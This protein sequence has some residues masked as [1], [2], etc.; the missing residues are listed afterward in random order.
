M[1]QAAPAAGGADG[2]QGAVTR[3]GVGEEASVGRRV[4]GDGGGF[5]GEAVG[6]Q[7]DGCVQSTCV[8]RW[9]VGADERGNEAK[10]KRAELKSV[11]DPQTKKRVGKSNLLCTRCE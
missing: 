9:E 2:V 11:L 5:Q 6:D 3:G 10:Q 1:G 4:D 7:P 8:G